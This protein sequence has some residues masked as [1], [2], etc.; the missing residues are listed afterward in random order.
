MRILMPGNSEGS[1]DNTVIGNAC[2]ALYELCLL[3]NLW[4]CG[5]DWD[6]SSISSL[7]PMRLFG[8]Q[9][10]QQPV[11]GIGRGMLSA[12]WAWGG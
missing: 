12:V 3:R 2:R 4:A 6:S 10:G 5:L 9:N 11:H 8:G 7:L 1:P